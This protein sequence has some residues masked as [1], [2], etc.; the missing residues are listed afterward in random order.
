[1]AP[2]A[3]SRKAARKSVQAAMSGSFG[4][5]FKGRIM[6]KIGHFIYASTLL[7]YFI[8]QNNFPPNLR[9]NTSFVY[10]TLAIGCLAQAEGSN[11]W[12]AL[13][14]SWWYFIYLLFFILAPSRIPLLRFIPQ[15]FSTA[16]CS[17]ALPETFL[18]H[19]LLSPISSISAE[20]A[21]FR[22]MDGALIDFASVWFPCVCMCVWRVI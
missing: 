17:P 15:P 2:P 4:C 1:M 10:G 12:S 5:V 16:F 20:L 8:L 13:C 22:L 6:R 11:T 14:N 19:F 7:F 18:S 9:G 21:L 3:T